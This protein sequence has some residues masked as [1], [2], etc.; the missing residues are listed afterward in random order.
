MGHFS[1]WATQRNRRNDPL[2]APASP[3]SPG[4]C[5]HGW[6]CGHVRGS[7]P[8]PPPPPGFPA[9][10]ADWELGNCSACANLRVSPA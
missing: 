2:S 5:A 4:A 3:G 1:S 6:E 7:G 8:P 9:S 10:S